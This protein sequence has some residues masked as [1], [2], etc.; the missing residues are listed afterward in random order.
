MKPSVGIVGCGRMGTALAKTLSC[1][2]YAI[3]GVSSLH[4]TSAEKLADICGISDATD[5]P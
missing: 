2:G 4:R 1:K 3:I 5:T